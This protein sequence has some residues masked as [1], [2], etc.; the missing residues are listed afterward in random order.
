MRTNYFSL[1]SLINQ[2]LQQIVS[3][4][5]LHF[6]TT[7]PSIT[8]YHL[9]YTFTIWDSQRPREGIF[10]DI[11][12]QGRNQGPLQDSQHLLCVCFILPSLP[13]YIDFFWS[14]WW[15]EHGCQKPLIFTPNHSNNQR[16]SES[17]SF[18]HL[19]KDSGSFLDQVPQP[20][21]FNR[22]MCV[23]R[24]ALLWHVPVAA[25]SWVMPRV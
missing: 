18:T 7:L 1:L 13:L 3:I 2:P 10:L 9:T 16:L 25:T 15:K 21:I 5:N 17:L 20:W 22:G 11:K 23:C 8:S 24:C 4:Q 6:I 12:T 19:E 14:F